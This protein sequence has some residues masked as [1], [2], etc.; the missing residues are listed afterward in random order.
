ML[1]ISFFCSE[2]VSAEEYLV[3]QKDKTFSVSTLKIKP[4]DKVVFK[5]L[6]PFNH[7]IY[8]LSDVKMFDLGSYPQGESR[9]VTF[10]SAGLIDVECAI[11]PEMKMTVE[12]AP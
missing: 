6:D 9:T 4:G 10:D 7:N 2:F 1:L 11:H 12:V 5:N 8:S 3:E